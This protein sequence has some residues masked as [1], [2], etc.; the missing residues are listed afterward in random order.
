MARGG[1]TKIEHWLFDCLLSPELKD[2]ELKIVLF[3]IRY[4]KG[5]QRNT[6]RASYSYIS[7]G[8]GYSEATV[9]R[10]IKEL[11]D[12]GILS[13]QYEASGS[14]A[15][16]FKFEYSRMTTRYGHVRP[17]DMVTDD[18]D[19]MV[20]DDHQDIKED[21]KDK[22]I[23]DNKKASPLF[24]TKNINDYT[25]EEAHEWQEK[26]SAEDWQLFLNGKVWKE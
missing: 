10:I 2:A 24:P 17:H 9:K 7:N 19:I 26:L 13:V 8:T 20:T 12:K 22:Y 11:I 25:V 4:T 3:L 16:V 6:V 18:H 21:I 23:K 14:K 5:F 15:R 1:Y